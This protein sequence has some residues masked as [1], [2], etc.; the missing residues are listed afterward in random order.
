MQ[1]LPTKENALKACPPLEGGDSSPLAPSSS[2]FSPPPSATSPC[3]FLSARLDIAA[4]DWKTSKESGNKS[5]K[6]NIVDCVVTALK[7]QQSE[8]PH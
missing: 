1:G 6:Y 8:S 7:Q 4:T 3:S 2:P 5:D